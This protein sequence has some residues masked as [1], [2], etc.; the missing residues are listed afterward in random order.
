MTIQRLIAPAEWKASDD[1]PGTL[2]GYLSTFGNTDLQGDVIEPGAFAKTVN[3]VNKD[4][5]PLLADHNASVRNVLGTIVHAEEDSKGLRIRARFAADPD[6][7]AIR[8]KLLDGHLKAMSIG[9]EPK[10]WGIREDDDGRMVRVLKEVKLWEGSVVVFP[11]NPEALVDTVK[12]AVHHTIGFV[13]AGAVANGVDEGEVKAAI[14]AYAT[15]DSPPGEQPVTTDDAT[16]PAGEDTKDG[17]SDGDGPDD[18][19]E[20][21]D[22][23]KLKMYRADAVLA[24]RDPDEMTDPVTCAGMEARLD[25]LD[26]W[27]KDRN[28]EAEL[29]D[30][31]SQLRE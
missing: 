25:V 29:T 31:L 9:Y 11:A 6:A 27:V 18:T 8:Q 4:G 13:I 30:E 20:G 22:S 5:I 3:K 24:G 17:S 7:Q 28:R 15:A 1:G 10:E 14:R 16:S 19:N 21:A 23:L 2:E 26:Q 12:S